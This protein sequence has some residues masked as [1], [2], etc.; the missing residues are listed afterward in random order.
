MFNLKNDVGN[1]TI[2][3]DKNN[4]VNECSFE[5]YDVGIYHYLHQYLNTGQDVLIVDVYGDIYKFLIEEI[6]ISNDR[7]KTFNVWGRSRGAL[8]ADPI[9]VKPQNYNYTTMRSAHSLLQELC[10]GHSISLNFQD[11]YIP[12]NTINKTGV[13]P[14][15]IIKDIVNAGSL[16]MYSMPDGSLVFEDYYQFL[17]FDLQEQT[18]VVEYVDYRDD[19]FNI[20]IQYEN[21]D[22]YN[23][24]LVNGYQSTTTSSSILIELDDKRNNGRTEFNP[25]D[26]VFINVYFTGDITVWD[27]LINNGSINYLGEIILD[28]EEEIQITS[29]EINL[30]YPIYTIDNIVYD[31]DS[32]GMPD[33]FEND[34][35]LI[36]NFDYTKVSMAN[37][38]YKTKAHL[39]SATRDTIGKLLFYLYEEG[40]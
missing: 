5:F 17:V 40:E 27:E 7:E 38:K 25:N 20:D 31:G 39:Y 16:T 29:K 24:V 10:F 28:K 30:N 26:I 19:I 21:G 22:N 33:Y 23:A 4:F 1:I 32:F 14:I 18:N 6:N 36:F 34:T 9:Y 13:L 2:N 37:I 8:L 11:F 12:A 3:M 15:D 35:R